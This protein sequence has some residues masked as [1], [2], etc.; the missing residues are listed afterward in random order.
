MSLP[1][2]SE[3]P[4][5]CL[6]EKKKLKSC[7]KILVFLP[8]MISSEETPFFSFLFS[9]VIKISQGFCAWCQLLAMF[10]ESDLLDTTGLPFGA[11]LT[12]IGGLFL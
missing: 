10:V 2:K 5:L 12:I 3:K 7:E 8:I 9:G 1:S 6:G 11:I 4:E